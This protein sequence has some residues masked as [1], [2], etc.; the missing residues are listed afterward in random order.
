[1]SPLPTGIAAFYDEID[2][3]VRANIRMGYVAVREGFQCPLCADDVHHWESILGD[4]IDEVSRQVRHGTAHR[5]LRDAIGLGRK[6]VEDQYRN[7]GRTIHNA[8]DDAKT[9]FNGGVPAHLDIITRAMAD[10]S[11]NYLIEDALSRH[12]PEDSWDTRVAMM[13]EFLDRYGIILPDRL[14]NRPP[15]Q[16]AGEYRTLLRN[17][18]DTKDRF[19]SDVRRA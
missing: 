5:N 1:M 8:I 10:E 14:L 3:L 7:N 13:R 19:A 4:Y 18:L 15:E 9:G 2:E 6:L 11:I 12:I 16:L 17:F